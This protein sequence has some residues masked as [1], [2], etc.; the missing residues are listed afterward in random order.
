MEIDFECFAKRAIIFEKKRYAMWIFEQ[1]KE[2]WKDHMKYRGLE[3]RRRDWCQIV[4]ETMDIIFQLILCEGKVNE[5]W[6]Y[7]NEIILSVKSLM[8]IRTNAELAEKL[9]L[10]RKIG[11]INGYAN[12]QPHV[13]CYQKMKKRGETLPGL[14]DRIRYMA[15]PGA[16]RDGISISV[17]TMDYIISTD[18]RIDNHWYI[19]KQ[20]IPPLER[21]FSAIGIDIT[22]GKK[23]LTESSLF[24]FESVPKVLNTEKQKVVL[25]KKTGLFAFQ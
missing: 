10:S 15:L 8:D 2:G 7:A 9:V 17:D 3:L 19:E 22:T 5:S 13:T 25:P 12:I 6:K 21:V 18:G 14:G 4:G 24:G 11:D 23:K 1:G 16:L 20:I